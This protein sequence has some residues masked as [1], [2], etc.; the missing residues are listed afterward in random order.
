MT[1]AAVPLRFAS[2]EPLD[3]ASRRAAPVRSYPRPSLLGDPLEVRHPRTAAALATLR[4]DTPGGLLGRL[5]SSHEVA[6]GV[7]ADDVRAEGMTPVYPATEGITSDR[8]RQLVKRLRGGEVETVERLPGRL[9][10]AERLPDR[11]A[12]LAA[13]HFPEHEAETETA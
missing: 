3:A 2:A 9:R 12:A 10:A 4:N 6:A 7:T 5:Q 11:A 13:V 8:L 1:A